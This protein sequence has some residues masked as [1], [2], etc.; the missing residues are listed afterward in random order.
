MQRCWIGRLAGLAALALTAACQSSAGAPPKPIATIEPASG[1]KAP[2]PAAAK[3]AAQPIPIDWAAAP[4]CLATLRLLQEAALRDR[5]AKAAAPLVSV[6]V[7]GA[8]GFEGWLEPKPLQV[9]A[10]LPL[11]VYPRG[12]AEA[13]AAP[14]AIEIQPAQDVRSEHRLVG[15]ESVSS[16]MQSG[17]RTEHNPDYDVARAGLRH[18]ERNSRTSDVKVMRVGDPMLDLIGVVVGGVLNGFGLF[19]GRHQVDEALAELA[20]TPRSIERPVYRPYQFERTTLRAR[21]EAVI[22]LT[23]HDREHRQVW[24]AELR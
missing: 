5:L 11:P 18:A 12:T 1:P 10:D 16:V 3:P 22:P 24:H 13:E 6:L 21:K 2:R 8:P 15:S 4:D 17:V 7:P 20:D 23:L 19:E 14:C 9:V